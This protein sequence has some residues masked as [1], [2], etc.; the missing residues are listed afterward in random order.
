[1]PLASEELVDEQSLTDDN[2]VINLSAVVV[3]LA[4]TCISRGA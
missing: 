1:M 3:R 4:V 2:G